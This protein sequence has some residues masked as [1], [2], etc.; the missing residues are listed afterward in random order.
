MKPL[1]RN[2]SNCSSIG[3]ALIL[4]QIIIVSLL[5][6]NLLNQR[7]S[8][9]TTEF[10]KPEAVINSKNLLTVMTDRVIQDL[11][12]DS[13]NKIT[14]TEKIEVH[15]AHPLEIIDP[16][17]LLNSMKQRAADHF[18]IEPIVESKNKSQKNQICAPKPNIFDLDY[19]NTYWQKL[20]IKNLTIHL[21]SAY[22][23]DRPKT[24]KEPVV[25]I[26][27]VASQVEP[28][29]NLFCQFWFYNNKTATAGSVTETKIYDLIWNQKYKRLKDESGQFVGQL[30]TCPVPKGGRV[31][32]S[33]SL[34]ENKCDQARNHL[35]VHNERR[36]PKTSPNFLVCVKALDF[37]FD[38]LSVELVQF[39][40]LNLMFGVDRIVFHNFG[41]HPNIEKVLSYYRTLE[42]ISVAPMTLPA[43]Y[44]NEPFLRHQ[45][46]KTR[47]TAKIVQE[48]IPYNDCFYR[49]MHQYDYILLLDIDEVFVP[50]KGISYQDTIRLIKE[51]DKNKTFATYYAPNKIFVKNSKNAPANDITQ[52]VPLYLTMLTATSVAKDYEWPYRVNVK[53]FFN[54][55]ELLLLNNHMPYKCLGANGN[56][57]K[58]KLVDDIVQL[59]HYRRK[60]FWQDGEG[61]KVK[62]QKKYKVEENTL[63]LRFKNKIISS[64]GKV[65]EELNIRN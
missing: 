8:C 46:I 53:S 32:L 20:T 50:A 30:I 27:T 62:E 57:Q 61:C 41:S 58:R 25:R 35:V 54:T 15:D 39:I 14:T 56:C 26:L 38:D 6:L 3:R 7:Q 51:Q 60:C 12:T 10:I 40:E 17:E 5:I 48:L 2:M 44:P 45:F 64:V 13:S 34:T 42:K 21:F 4:I 23:D 1:I 59:H 9:D 19:H 24:G 36:Q 55:Q 22:Y 28:K 65:M 47:H 16:Q 49:H 31:P 43:G 18:I 11:V 37:L 63:M 29:T 33:V 52:D